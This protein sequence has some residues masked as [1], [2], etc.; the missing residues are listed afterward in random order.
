MWLS[1]LI[2]QKQMHQR[3][4]VKKSATKAILVQKNL[5]TK[6]SL[7]KINY[8]NSRVNH[9]QKIFGNHYY[10]LYPKYKILGYRDQFEKYQI[11]TGSL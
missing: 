4:P 6:R 1:M 8:K 9:E 2:T 10:G 3:F 11:G 7:I 5:Q